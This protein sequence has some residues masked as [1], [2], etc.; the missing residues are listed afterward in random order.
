MTL[1]HHWTLDPSVTFLNHGS[2]GACPR[3]VLEHQAELRAELER[4]PVQ[5]MTKT[6]PAMLE[7]ARA[8]AAHFVGAR[9]EDVVFVRNAT[10]AVNAVLRSIRLS[11][12][13]ELL[14]TDHVYNACRNAL[15]CV[16]AQ[17]GARVVVAS[18]PF[19][20]DSEAQVIERILERASER[21][22]LLLIDHVTSP[23][24]LVIPVASI[25]GAL[26]GCDVLV[27]GAHAP[28]MLDLDIPAT[29]VAYYAAN[30]HKWTCAPK[31]AGMLWVRSDR[32]E[33]LHPAVISHGYNSNRARKKFLE[34]F[35]WTGTDDPTAW[36]TVPAAIRFIESVGGS[37]N[38]VRAKNRALAL[39]ARAIL[40][41]AL[42][43][44]APSPESM[45]GSLAAV[46]LPAGPG[47]PPMGALYV[48]PLQESLFERHRI[49]VPVPPWPAPPAR[50]LRVSAH[51][52]NAEEEYHR[53]AAA[54]VDEL[55]RERPAA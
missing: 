32:Q 21:T 9:S 52:Y 6:L 38:A 15:N 46:P 31:G 37:W 33:G 54:L 44:P 25:A 39:R 16:A 42:E 24:G 45:V 26:P 1:L 28:G 10:T 20:V 51:L 7:D 48:D 27:D 4:E 50:V 29:G 23:T 53:L 19:P 5:F 22:R 40:C 12:G 11:P 30:F 17:A 41:E 49:E 3:A 55:E 2:F 47:G 8:F 36:L 18:I 34:E 13:D 43:I 35:D 14:T